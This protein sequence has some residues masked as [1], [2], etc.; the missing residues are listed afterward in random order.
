MTVTDELRDRI[1][2]EEGVPGHGHRLRGGNVAQLR[3][4][5]VELRAELGRPD[6]SPSMASA[7]AAQQRRQAERNARMRFR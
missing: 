7:V 2:A 1:A 3:A 4:D 5:A 6:T